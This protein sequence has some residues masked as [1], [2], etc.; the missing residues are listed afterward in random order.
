VQIPKQPV[1]RWLGA[2]L[3]NPSSM[4]GARVFGTEGLLLAYCVEKLSGKSGASIPV[5]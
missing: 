4:R 3:N 1:A 2:L 5:S